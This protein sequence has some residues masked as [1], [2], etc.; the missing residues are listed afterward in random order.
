MNVLIIDDEPGLR[1]TVSLILTEEGYDVTT[2]SDGEEG[3]AKALEGK[4]DIV[5]CDVRMPRL[6]G[7]EFLERFKAQDGAGMVIVMT[8]YGGMD[9]AIQA[10]KKGAYV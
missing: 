3:L 9:L 2:A 5:L 10:M 8:A 4:P 6:N 1:H 7:L